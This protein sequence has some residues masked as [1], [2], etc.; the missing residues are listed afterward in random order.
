MDMVER[1]NRSR[2]LGIAAASPPASAVGS[3]SG[4]ESQTPQSAALL[5]DLSRQLINFQEKFT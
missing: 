4:S 2:A 1:N 5:D 3:A